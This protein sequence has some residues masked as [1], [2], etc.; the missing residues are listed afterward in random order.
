MKILK[1]LTILLLCITVIG[2]ALFSYAYFFTA[3]IQ[4]FLSG[5]ALTLIAG[6]ASIFMIIIYTILEE[7]NN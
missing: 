4:L 6:L 7:I 5:V 2:F 1:L 3:D